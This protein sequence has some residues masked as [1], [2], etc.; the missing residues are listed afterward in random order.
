MI[1]YDGKNDFKAQQSVSFDAL[2]VGFYV[3]KILGAK[4]ETIDTQ[5]GSF[6]RLALQIDVAEGEHANHYRK[7]YEA[8]SG[9]SYPAKFKGIV[10]ISIPVK[11]SQYEATQ[12]RILENM[13]WALEQSNKGYHWDWDETKLK[14]LSVGFT[15]REFDW[16]M[17]RDGGLAYGTSTEIGR[18]DSVEDAR[19]GKLKPM[20]KRELREADKEKLQR[21]QETMA[22][23][24][25]NGMTPLAADEELPF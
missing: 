11:G 9:G 22:I 4:V 6:D 5:S 8:Q 19:S 23:A 21:Y 25:E 20:K 24:E 15:V 2:P 1:N 17:E 13:A 10:R 3:G 18:L 14:G 16:C 12:K 7:Q